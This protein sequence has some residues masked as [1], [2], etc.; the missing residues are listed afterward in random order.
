MRITHRGQK[1]F[2]S[3]TGRIDE[4]KPVTIIMTAVLQYGGRPYT[5]AQRRQRVGPLQS[6]G[7]PAPGDKV[8]TSTRLICDLSKPAMSRAKP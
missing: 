6:S 3:K 2:T 5:Y 4:S 1:L 8:W 7:E